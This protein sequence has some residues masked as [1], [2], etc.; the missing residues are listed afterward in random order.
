MN[1][2]VV[3]ILKRIEHFKTKFLL[4]F[5]FHVAPNLF[6]RRS[7]SHFLLGCDKTS[8]EKNLDPKRLGK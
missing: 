8:K 5:Y 7:K 3:V 6:Q 4:Y 1:L 2:I